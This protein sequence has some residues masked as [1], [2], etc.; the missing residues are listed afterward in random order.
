MVATL[1]HRAVEELEIRQE[2]MNRAVRSL[3]DGDQLEPL[4]MLAYFALKMLH[5]VI[6]DGLAHLVRGGIPAAFGSLLLCICI[7]EIEKRKN[8]VQI[9]SDGACAQWCCSLSRKYGQVKCARSC[10]SNTR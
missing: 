8:S 10:P 2:H 5:Q 1:L 6:I 4:K 9:R 3:C 7:Q